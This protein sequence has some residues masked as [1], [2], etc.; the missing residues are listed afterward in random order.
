MR[1]ALVR[2]RRLLREQGVAPTLALAWSA[3]WMRL[4]WWPVVGALARRAAAAARPP[5][6]GQRL[7]ARFHPRGFVSPAAR[8][9]HPGLV[10]GRH[11]YVGPDVLIYAD[12]HGGTVELGDGVHLYDGTWIQTGAEGSVHIGAGSSLQPRCQLS[13]Y[14][15]RIEIGRGVAIAPQCAFYPYDHLVGD[16]ELRM[17][18]SKGPIVVGDDAV[19][20]YGVT[21]LSGVRIG[22]RAVVGAGS[23]VTRDVP[24]D[25]VAAGNPARVLRSRAAVG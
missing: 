5:F 14:V 17:L 24:D 8:L 1:T 20:G 6:Y 2:A 13:A 9:A 22:R 23:V 12:G 25:A 3:G 21:V 11:V 18:S 19:L 10:T 16:G 7:L 4:A 15:S